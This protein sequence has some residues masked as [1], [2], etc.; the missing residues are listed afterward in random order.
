MYWGEF[1]AKD[2]KN[3]DV[4]YMH[5]CMYVLKYLI[6]Y[7]KVFETHHTKIENYIEVHKCVNYIRIKS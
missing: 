6:K 3:E 1:D 7:L 5:L 4:T 2:E